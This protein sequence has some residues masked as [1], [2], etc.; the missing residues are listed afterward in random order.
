[1]V[2]IELRPG[3]KSGDGWIIGAPESGSAGRNQPNSIFPLA[4]FSN[5][6]NRV[7][8]CNFRQLGRSAV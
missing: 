6:A 1:M 2:F 5:S 8:Q 7:Q 3:D 4:A